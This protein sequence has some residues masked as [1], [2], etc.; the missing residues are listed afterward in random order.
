MYRSAADSFFFY[1]Y[2]T[3]TPATDLYMGI[4]VQ[5][6]GVTGGFSNTADTPGVQVGS[7]TTLRFKLGQND[8]WF[9]TTTKNFMIVMDLGK[10]YTAGGGTCRLQLRRVVVPTA[11]AA[12][13]YAIPLS[14]FA[15]V[16]DCGGAATSV[17]QAL[18][19]SP[20]SQIAFQGVGGG[21]ALSDGT[22]TSGANRSVADG[23]GRFAT[24]L[25]LQGGIRID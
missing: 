14:S 24:T 16:Q 13:D 22:R 20:I 17:A 5:A 2:Q 19:A 12:S 9:A 6:P 3:A 18:A 1:Y 7:Q 8:Q 15:L 23:N 4:Y 10:R 25:V 11:A 21:I